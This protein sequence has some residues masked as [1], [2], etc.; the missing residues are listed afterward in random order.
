MA[1]DTTFSL[2]NGLGDIVGLQSANLRVT[3]S[4]LPGSRSCAVPPVGSKRVMLSGG[5]LK[6]GS[7][8]NPTGS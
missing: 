2:A 8:N 7:V 3:A 1:S 5:G 6:V 4:F